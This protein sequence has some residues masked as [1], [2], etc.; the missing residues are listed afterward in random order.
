MKTT[1]LI[2][3]GIAALSIVA[4]TSVAIAQQLA[5][6]FSNPN[7]APIGVVTLRT[8]SGSSTLLD[9]SNGTSA[10]TSVPG[11]IQ[12]V[13]I[14]GQVVVRPYAQLVNLSGSVVVGVRWTGTSYIEVFDPSEWNLEK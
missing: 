9:V 1:C 3:R 11:S 12:S 14:N 2:L 8:A 6:C 4:L 5:F 10:C 13:V 7:G